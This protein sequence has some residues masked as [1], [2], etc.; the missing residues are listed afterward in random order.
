MWF[1]VPKGFDFVGRKQFFKTIIDK[2]ICLNNND[3]Y[4]KTWTKPVALVYSSVSGTG[5]TVALLELKQKLKNE[6]KMALHEM[7]IT[8]K[9]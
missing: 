3:E 6:E 1:D 8:Q 9:L 7:P 4:L 2:I 5:K